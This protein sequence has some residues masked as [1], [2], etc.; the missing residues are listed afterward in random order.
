MSK[1]TDSYDYYKYLN[2]KSL[3]FLAVLT[4]FVA[5]L[6]EDLHKM[7]KK[8]LQ[9]LPVVTN[10]IVCYECLIIEGLDIPG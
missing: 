7:R 2:M 8:D 3:I 6:K 9:V 5:G 1:I 4:V 10:I